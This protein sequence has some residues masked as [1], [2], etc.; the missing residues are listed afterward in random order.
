MNPAELILHHSQTHTLIS[1]SRPQLRRTCVKRVKKERNK[2][3]EVHV[4]VSTTNEWT[5]AKVGIGSAARLR[6]LVLIS[7]CNKANIL[8]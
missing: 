8:K 4:H 5:A 1:A 3:G 7:R 6:R 2:Q